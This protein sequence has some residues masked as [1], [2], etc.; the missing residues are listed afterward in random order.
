[1]TNHSLCRDKGTHN[2]SPARKHG[3]FRW[4]ALAA[5]VL[6]LAAAAGCGRRETPSAK[7]YNLHL[8]A[9]DNA[10]KKGD[11]DA[12]LRSY[13][14]AGKVRNC[15][16]VR[17]KISSACLVM[18]E[19]TTDVSRRVALLE[20]AQK[21]L[22]TSETFAKLTKARRLDLARKR[23]AFNDAM[24]RGAQAAAKADWK[25]AASAFERSIRLAKVAG[26]DATQARK[27]ATAAWEQAGLRGDF[28][29]HVADGDNA[30][31]KK[32]YAPAEAAYA[33]ALKLATGMKG[34]PPER[35]KAVEKKR[36]DVQA[37]VRYAAGDK[38]A[39][40]AAAQRKWPAALAE[41]REIA[42]LAADLRPKPPGYARLAHR[43]GKAEVEVS[44]TQ[45]ARLMSEAAQALK[46]DDLA[47]ASSALLSAR[48][49][50][51]DSAAKRRL[52]RRI[53]HRA[54]QLKPYNTA[55]ARLKLARKEGRFT[56]ILAASR[57]VI[58]V[59]RKITPR[60][61]GLAA[62]AK[63]VTPLEGEAGEVFHKN[64][65]AAAEAEKA[66]KLDLAAG[67]YEKAASVAAS[68]TGPL[69]KAASLRAEIKRRRDYIRL[70]KAATLAEAA[71]D[72]APALRDYEKARKI[73]SRPKALDKP[74]A[75]VTARLKAMNRYRR[76]LAEAKNMGQDARLRPQVEAWRKAIDSGGLMEPPPRDLKANVAV[77]RE[78]C[79]RLE[80]AD[81][82][83]DARSAERDGHAALAV[84]SYAAARM[85]AKDT[86]DI[87]KRLPAL[88][89][90]AD[91][92]RP[93]REALNR[94]NAYL[95]QRMF[96][97][98]LAGYRGAVAVGKTIKPPPRDMAT[99]E[100]TI[101]P[102]KRAR[103][104]YVRDLLERAS[105]DWDSGFLAA[106]LKKS[107]EARSIT[108]DPPRK[109]DIRIARLRKDIETRRNSPAAR[110]RA[111]EQNAALATVIARGDD[112]FRSGSHEHAVAAYNSAMTLALA[113]R[114]LP[115]ALP[116]LRDR[117]SRARR[118]LAPPDS[119]AGSTGIRIVLIKPGRFIMGSNRGAPDE[120]PPH[121]VTIT[122]PFYMG[123]T[124]ICNEQYARFLKE[125]GHPPPRTIMGSLPWKDGRFDP[126]LAGRPVTGVS[127]NDALAFCKWLS[128]KE[129]EAYRLPTEAEWE[130]AC[131]AG[132]RERYYWGNKASPSRANYE[133]SGKGSTTPVGSYKPN[134][135]NLCDMAGNAYDWC[136]DGY[137]PYPRGART[138][139]QGKEGAARRVIRGGWFRSP[140]ADITSARRIAEIPVQGYPW[141]SFRVV[142]TA[143]LKGKP[144]PARK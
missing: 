31:T 83:A 27:N 60:P 84:E 24:N 37:R 66:D 131:R 89:K 142:V 41:L 25:T 80:Y 120:K 93:Y 133:A 51:S 121:L 29:G 45:T 105:K 86:A 22:P 47:T 144:A 90:R 71:D 114:P 49:L 33:T 6:V 78:L 17:G 70:L 2:M 64:M 16:E 28:D 104:A 3:T 46:R 62:I 26:M 44:K 101:E 11:Y 67:L 52:G 138:D 10:M 5:A 18:A 129:G 119:F 87:D 116:R 55:M 137:G 57:A 32:Q 34:L 15:K 4:S 13:A 123:A 21:A 140:A 81:R 77:F 69:A 82:I 132:S 141:T 124:Q 99:T 12:A 97:E 96:N 98:A 68:P 85:V 126:K 48:K 117:L 8:A 35:L 1:M 118:K 38:A 76:D 43:I 59:G 108:T 135:W 39:E 14:N 115:E 136:L 125:T 103:R 130:Y 20:R 94:A 72:L 79:R 92:L 122:R 73:A 91:T 30:E 100:A 61:A 106:A 111:T 75:R 113:M 95:R 63:E 23:R 102:I 128:K 110:E 9:G 50:T 19:R 53:E 88:R 107:L 109:L 65:A 36:D 42:K 54:A 112:F 143:P 7:L 58:E 127:Y 40:I 56:A 139:P 134:A 74:I